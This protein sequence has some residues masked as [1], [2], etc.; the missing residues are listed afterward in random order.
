MAGLYGE[1]SMAGFVLGY[2]SENI[3]WLTDAL[4]GI[5]QTFC[6]NP[7]PSDTLRRSTWE[8]LPSQACLRVAGFSDTLG[9]AHK[10][11]PERTEK[12]RQFVFIFLPHL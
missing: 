4:A 10:P 12:Y 8:V 9:A 11:E 3:T 2:Q 7:S 5:G 6:S 1:V